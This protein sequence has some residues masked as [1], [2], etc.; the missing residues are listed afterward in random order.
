MRV[1]STP[2]HLRIALLGLVTALACVVGSPAAG[3]P[4]R[5]SIFFLRGEQLASVQRPGATPLV[6]MRRLIAGPTPAEG[7]QGFRTYIPAG[8]RGPGVEVGDGGAPLEPNPRGAA[9]GGP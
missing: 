5:V 4:P 1:G 9:G 8:T 7:K 2:R 6:A 3:A